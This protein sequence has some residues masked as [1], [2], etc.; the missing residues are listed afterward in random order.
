MKVNSHKPTKAHEVPK[1]IKY[2][3]SFSATNK[4][5]PTVLTFVRG[6]L[7]AASR[8]LDITAFLVQCGDDSAHLRRVDP[9]TSAS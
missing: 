2:C 6:H 8:K 5:S 9:F 3:S 4:S 7:L 1:K